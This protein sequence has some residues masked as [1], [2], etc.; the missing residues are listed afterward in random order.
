M[1][2]VLH[3]AT[4]KWVLE[5]SNDSNSTGLALLDQFGDVFQL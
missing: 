3:F 1:N 2:K 5:E 4:I